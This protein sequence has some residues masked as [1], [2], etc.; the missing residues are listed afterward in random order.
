M[1]TTKGMEW[2]SHGE[3]LMEPRLFPLQE[4]TESENATDAKFTCGMEENMEELMAQ[5]L[6][7]CII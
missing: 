3:Q 6:F 7:H 4:T 1:V 2:L 5:H